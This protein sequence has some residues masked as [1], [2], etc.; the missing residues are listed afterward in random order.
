ML[1]VCDNSIP[2]CLRFCVGS[3]FCIP[4]CRLFCVGS[5]FCILLCLRFCVRS[6]FCIVVLSALS[7]FAVIFLRMGELDALF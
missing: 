3:S 5:L 2:L 7:S 1:S 6:L 4:L